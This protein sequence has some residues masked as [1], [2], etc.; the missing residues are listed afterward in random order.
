[1]VYPRWLTSRRATD[2]KYMISN[3]TIKT[4]NPNINFCYEDIITYL[5]KQNTILEL[6]K[7]SRKI[8][9]QI[10]K[11]VYKHYIKI[12]QSHHIGQWNQ[13][14][15]QVQW[16]DLWKNTL[17]SYNWLEN[18]SI[19]YLLLHFATRANDQ[20]NRWINQKQMKSPNCK[21]TNPKTNN[22]NTNPHMENKKQTTIWRYNHPS[23]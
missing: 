18:N 19:L 17:Y 1:M 8:Y 22:H 14:S 6:P 21:E 20:I 4:E 2:V 15:P 5:K 12:G 11:N 23:Y 3:N 7:K 13:Y 16:N 10:I 9:K